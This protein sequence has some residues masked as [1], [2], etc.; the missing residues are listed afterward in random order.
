LLYRQNEIAVI[1]LLVALLFIATEIG[2]KR[3][4]AARAH[5]EEAARSHH[6]TLQTGVMGLLALL[7]AFT[8][9][10]SSTRYD[11]RKLLLVDEVNA[12]GTAWLRSRMLPEPDRSTIGGLI[13]DY[14]GF[15]L[16]YYRSV[17]GNRST[18]AALVKS[19]ELRNQFW[20]RAAGMAQK[21]PRSIPIGLFV[22][23]LN[24][25]INVAARRD[26][27]REN[28]VP[29]PVLFFL[30]LVCILTM[31]L[32]GYGCGL[33]G[34]RS[35]SAT[36]AIGL[37]IGLVILVILDLDRPRRGFIEISQTP[38]IELRQSLR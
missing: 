8:F 10:M 5:L 26:A 16:E 20:S 14:A 37:F 29:E 1:T 6:S 33:G 35:F 2:F 13:R 32:L 17:A 24:D 27:A 28:H 12:I 25:L 36:A 22:S 7:L 34:H 15:R 11:T 18:D 21:D 23:S 19:Q 3:G 30:F 4:L 38:M 31:G 9:S